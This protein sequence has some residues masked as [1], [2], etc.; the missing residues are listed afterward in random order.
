M[1]VDYEEIFE[2]TFII[3]GYL[4]PEEQKEKV[5]KLME[6]AGI[7]LTPEEK[8]VL[9][10]SYEGVEDDNGISTTQTTKFVVRRPIERV[11]YREP[12]YDVDYHTGDTNKQLVEKQE[13]RK[14]RKIVEKI[15][16][17]IDIDNKEIYGKEYLFRRFYLDKLSEKVVI[18]GFSCY[19][20]DY[21]D[22]KYIINNQNNNYSPYQVETRE[23]RMG[24][25]EKV[26]KECSYL[27][28]L[29]PLRLFFNFTQS[30]Y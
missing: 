9:V 22:A 8:R 6:S 17:Y 14:D 13:E 25:K 10:I 29:F 5:F 3:D 20:M 19:K 24:K 15:T 7:K 11:P 1:P 2:G 4:T 12:N 26:P 16:L 27:K 28:Y 21:E 30:I 23:V 18:D